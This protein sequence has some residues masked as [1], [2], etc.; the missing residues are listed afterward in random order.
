MFHIKTGKSSGR[1]RFAKLAACVSAALALSIVSPGLAAASKAENAAPEKLEAVTVT[2]NKQKENLQ[3][4]SIS[5]TVLN[6]PAIEDRQ[7]ENINE[8]GDFIP[9][10]MIFSDGPAGINSP[11]MRGIHADAESLT[12]T[13]GLFVDEIPI[14][15][16]LGFAAESFLDIE[17][18]EVLRGPQGT[19]YGK[20]TEVGAINIITRLPDN[21]YRGKAMTNLGINAQSAAFNLS[22]PIMQ[23]KLYFGISGQ[24]RREKGF[25]EHTITGDEVDDRENFYGKGQLRWTPRD[26]LEVRFIMSHI[27]YDDG[28]YRMGPN[29]GWWSGS[30]PSVPGD[31]KVSSDHEGYSKSKETSQALKISYDINEALS[32][33]STTTHRVFNDVR[34]A[35][36]D[37]TSLDFLWRDFDSE[38]R[39]ITEELRLNYDAD[40]FKWLFGLYYDK[41]DYDIKERAKSY[42]RNQDVDGYSYALFGQVTVPLTSRLSVIGGLRYEYQKTDFTDNNTGS[43][44]DGS[45][46]DISPKLALEYQFNS[47]VMGYASVAK[48]FRSGGI[49]Y[50]W[51]DPAKIT[52]DSEKLWSYEVGVKSQ[53]LDNRLLLNGAVYRMDIQDMQVYDGYPPMRLDISNSAQAVGHGFELEMQAL[54]TKNLALD[55]GFGYS[56][57]EFED[58]TEGG[59]SYDGNKSPYAPEYTFNIGAQYRAEN[60]FY[61]RIDMVGYG[62]MYL[63]KTNTYSRDPYTLVNAKIGYEMENLDIYLY[64]KNLFDTRYDTEGYYGGMFILYGEPREVGITLSYRF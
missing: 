12:V 13:T 33:T 42:P 63:D 43:K 45:W 41:N 37:L 47:E 35:D 20:N 36:I 19:L 62:K 44:L 28:A 60:G 3:D 9:N 1:K 21:Q 52:Y 61:T 15:S 51:Y 38:Y 26:D 7:I 40:R 59:V 14:A 50:K 53:L 48:G 18:I 8:L 22:G 29:P 64:G 39:T 55:A 11:S 56:K 30:L 17:R 25:I 6:G 23:D 10:L 34:G 58:F 2:A 24:C 54:I 49:N 46:D 27:K 4:V 31:R 32:L 16:T 57:V 5:M